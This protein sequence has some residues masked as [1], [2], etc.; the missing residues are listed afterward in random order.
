MPLKPGWY[1]FTASVYTENV[2]EVDTGANNPS[3]KLETWAMGVRRLS[4]KSHRT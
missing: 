3:F 2:G 1:P 4:S